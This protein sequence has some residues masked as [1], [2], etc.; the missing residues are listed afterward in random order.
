MTNEPIKKHLEALLKLESITIAQFK[1]C[2]RIL[3]N[4]DTMTFSDVR[5]L[6][7]LVSQH[8]APKVRGGD[9]WRSVGSA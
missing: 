1:D 7:N 8:L 2:Q 4:F 5:M 9:G 6:E 3:Q